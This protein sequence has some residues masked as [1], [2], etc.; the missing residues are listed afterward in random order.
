MQILTIAEI[1]ALSPDQWVLVGYPFL[2]DFDK[3]EPFI[4]KIVSGIVLYASKDKRE[5]ASKSKDLR[6]GYDYISCINTGEY[7]QNAGGCY[8]HSSLRDT[9]QLNQR[10]L[11]PHAHSTRKA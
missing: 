1:K 7:P 5:I 3:L 4:N 6:D 9:L 2:K 8:N 11:R 10:N